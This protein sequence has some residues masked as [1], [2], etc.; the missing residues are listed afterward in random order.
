MGI[1]IFTLDPTRYREG[2]YVEGMNIPCSPNVKDLTVI[3]HASKPS[4]KEAL[5]WLPHIAYRMVWVCAKPPSTNDERVIYDDTYTKDSGFDL[6]LISMLRLRDRKK[7]FDVLSGVP[8]PVVIPYLR[9]NHKDLRLWKNLIN[10][11]GEVPVEYQNAFVAYGHNPEGGWVFKPDYPQKSQKPIYGFRESDKYTEII[12][13]NCKENAN[14]VRKNDI[15]TLP[16]G[17]KKR[18][19]RGSEWL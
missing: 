19:E 6:A 1:L 18:E 12:V 8:M 7:V 14:N 13:R 5:S 16:K 15:D 10:S 3:T 9:K 2:H 4:V 11:F 17:M